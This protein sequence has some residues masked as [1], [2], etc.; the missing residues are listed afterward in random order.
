M[1]TWLLAGLALVI[2]CGG[3][4]AYG[5]CRVRTRLLR[6]TETVRS[7]L[8]K[9]LEELT[10]LQQ[11]TLTLSETL[12]LDH[13]V[14]EIATFVRGFVEADG[15]LVA[16]APEDAATF[17]IAAADGCVSALAGSEMARED[18]GLLGEAL[19]E[20]RVTVS[21]P[22]DD[23]RPELVAG[24]GVKVAAVAPL[25]AHG[26]VRGVLAAVR[27]GPEP[28]TSGDI[29]QLVTVATH[30]A[31]ALAHASSVELLKRGKE[32]WE[33]TFD[34]LSTGIAVVD[35]R[36]Q[37]RRANKTL[38][39]MLN[40]PVTAV[41]GVNLA[42]ELPGDSALLVDYLD[43]IRDEGQTPPLT[44]VSTHPEKRF[45]ISASRMHRASAN[46]AVV[47]I[48]DVTERNVIEE[49]LI[50]SEKMAAVG[51]LVSGVAHDL[52]NPITSIAGVAD[53]L[54]NRVTSSPD[55]LEHFRMIHGQVGHVIPEVMHHLV[56]AT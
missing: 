56:P 39:G 32:Q 50:Q 54:M 7:E 11:L 22:E 35:G 26:K 51:Q 28:F 17:Q 37:I 45:Q 2:L 23:Q 47:Q 4:I 19:K 13:I 55:D 44:H 31:M 3:G 42:D 5:I 36:C 34:V 24:F 29:R 25:E 9:R 43:N 33:A 48:E 8:A 21:H 52:N 30:T 10:A 40:R 41:V 18:A 20:N 1:N 46:W 12:V 49:Q 27:D 53:L 15:V 14:G 16:L 6:D 38:A